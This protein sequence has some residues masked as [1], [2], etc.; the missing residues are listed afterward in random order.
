MKKHYFF[1]PFFFLFISFF[2]N[3]QQ[4]INNDL[5]IKLKG[6]NYQYQ[7]K[8]YPK[9]QVYKILVQDPAATKIYNEY[10]SRKKTATTF[11]Y[12]SG[13]L[14]VASI[15]FAAQGANEKQRPQIARAFGSSLI[16]GV[17]SLV[18]IGI[19]A[20]SLSSG[21]KNFNKSI[22]SFNNNV[23]E[24]ESLGSTPIQLNLHLSENGIG[25]VLNF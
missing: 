5:I 3:A 24:R 23:K 14:A 9:D 11:W 22:N 10:V 21:N 20:I 19:G 25:L 2:T 16:C 15:L 1:F 12:V 8:S 6:K 13:G 17:G 18:S 7:D 4:K